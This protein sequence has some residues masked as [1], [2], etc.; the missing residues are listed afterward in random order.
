MRR[1]IRLRFVAAVMALLAGSGPAAAGQPA[2][3]DATAV[4]QTVE[5]FLAELGQR[6]LDALPSLFAPKATMVV[7]RQRDGAWTSSHQTFD[8]WL[9]GLRAQNP[10]TVFEEPLTS[11]T[12][13]VESGHLAFLRADFTVVVGGQVRSHGVDY[14]T[15]VKQDGAWKIVNGAYTSIQGAP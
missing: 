12:V 6:H 2:N 15:L 13:H 5:R 14:F 11:V 7:V 4:R 10:G 8:E 9:A 3:A 1:A